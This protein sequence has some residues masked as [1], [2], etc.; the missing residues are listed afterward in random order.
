MNLTD[1]QEMS[2]VDYR[3][4]LLQ[5]DSWSENDDFSMNAIEKMSNRAQPAPSVA[6]LQEF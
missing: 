2:E 3:P 1:L 6:Q 4:Q 5:R